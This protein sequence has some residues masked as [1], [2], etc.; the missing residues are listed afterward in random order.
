MN[1]DLVAQAPP[2]R[3]RRN[4]FQFLGRL[5]DKVAW[6]TGAFLAAWEA[7]SQLAS[8]AYLGLVAFSTLWVA[9]PVMLTWSLIATVAFC[10]ARERGY[11][12]LL[13]AQE[14]PKGRQRGF[15]WYAMGSAIRA[16]LSGFQAFI[17]ARCSSFLLVEREQAGRLHRGMKYMVLGLGMTLF[18]VTTA[19]HML[20]R[21]GYTG[22]KLARVG[23]IGPFLNVPYR[24]LLSAAVIHLVRDG[25]G[26]LQGPVI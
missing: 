10:H 22:K 15:L 6:N 4:P 23:L 8:L 18:G 24:I 12:N 17:F 16:W 21:V 14:L 1:F 19:E 26:L 2:G 7:Q 3:L 25:L 20:R 9:L 11:P 13:T 5:H